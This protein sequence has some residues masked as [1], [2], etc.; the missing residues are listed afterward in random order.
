M[1]EAGLAGTTSAATRIRQA[2]RAAGTAV[3]PQPDIATMTTGLAG[4]AG[5]TITTVVIQQTTITTVAARRRGIGPITNQR[6]PQQHRPNNICV[7]A[8]ITPRTSCCKVCAAFAASALAYE[9]AP[10]LNVCTNWL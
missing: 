7:G 3:A 10:A 4:P 9:A 5:G 1:D 2:A 6:A 8:L